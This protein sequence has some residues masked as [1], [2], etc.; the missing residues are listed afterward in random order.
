MPKPSGEFGRP[1]PSPTSPISPNARREFAVATRRL[2][3]T[4]SRS[5]QPASVFLSGPS[6]PPPPLPFAQTNA[7]FSGLHSADCVPPPLQPLELPQCVPQFPSGHNSRSTGHNAYTRRRMIAP[8]LITS[9][10]SCNNLPPQDLS[11]PSS[12]LSSIFNS[13][14]SSNSTLSSPI[15]FPSVCNNQIPF[16]DD[17][18]SQVRDELHQE[19]KINPATVKVVE[20][21]SVEV[22]VEEIH[23]SLNKPTTF[24]LKNGQKYRMMC[25]P[26]LMNTEPSVAQQPGL[27]RKLSGESV[28]SS[29]STSSSTSSGS[30]SEEPEVLGARAKRRRAQP[31]SLVHMSNEEIA[32]RK[33]EQ[34]REAAIRYRQ[35]MRETKSSENVEKEKLSTRNAYLREEATRLEKEIND[36]RTIIHSFCS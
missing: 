24:A 16:I 4:P 13:S 27:K 35:K 25:E 31:V 20:K 14:I 5:A 28:R 23:V 10:T 18:I 22:V 32:L 30:D 2:I 6:P 34:N 7:V 1:T 15:S 36:L 33:K 17:L 21:S 3:A 9:S 26:I 19:S 12:H 11:P 8:L 29:C